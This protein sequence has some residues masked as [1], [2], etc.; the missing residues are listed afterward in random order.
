[1]RGTYWT[2]R[3]GQSMI[4]HIRSTARSGPGMAAMA[5]SRTEN[6]RLEKT[7]VSWKEIAVY[8]NRA[9][10]TV[11][12]WERERGLPVHRVPGG[13]RGGVFAY[14]DELAE[15]LK[16]KSGDLEADNFLPSDTN[17]DHAADPATQLMVS[18]AEF[19]PAPS[20]ARHRWAVSPA[21]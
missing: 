12:R 18:P 2:P 10:R 19:V 1:M 17:S 20:S 15:W 14:P 16:G 3:H 7:L 9:E 4:L 13:E 21:R 6:S 5:S 8:L 11:K